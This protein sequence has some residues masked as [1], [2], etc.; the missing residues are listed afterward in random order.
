M[1]TGSTLDRSEWTRLMINVDPKA[2]RL[3]DGT[4]PAASEY[5]PR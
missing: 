3:R 4:I 2:T 1:V 5:R